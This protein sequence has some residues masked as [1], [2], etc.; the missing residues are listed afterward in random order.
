MCSVVLSSAKCKGMS[1]SSRA[2]HRVS[3]CEIWLRYSQERVRESLPK[4]WTDSRYCHRI[5][6][7][8]RPLKQ[9][10]RRLWPTACPRSLR[11]PWRF[12]GSCPVAAGPSLRLL[13]FFLR[14]DCNMKLH[15]E[16]ESTVP[17]KRLTPKV[18]QRQE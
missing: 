12:V 7:R 1:I 3:G 6:A 11:A 9:R 15:V 13:F 16:Y 10:S 18:A 2:F 5:P 17:G 14:C 4:V 8:K